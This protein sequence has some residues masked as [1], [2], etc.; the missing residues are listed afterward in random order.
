M[1]V[2]SV[3][4]LFTSD[5]PVDLPVPL[6]SPRGLQ[7]RKGTPLRASHNLAEGQSP[8]TYDSPGSVLGRPPGA[9]IGV[10]SPSPL[11]RTLTAALPHAKLGSFAL[12]GP[13]SL[14]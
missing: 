14:V 9:R 2:A 13:V 11:P 4:I 6:R 10:P 1:I 12:G 5:L 7:P 8:G 3:A